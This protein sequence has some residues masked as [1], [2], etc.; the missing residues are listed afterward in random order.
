MNII[1]EI[2][3]Y[4]QFMWNF[5]S[6][7]VRYFSSYIDL[8]PIIF[9]HCISHV[10][11][12]DIFSSTRMGINITMIKTNDFY[13]NILIYWLFD[14]ELI[15]LCAFYIKLLAPACSFFIWECP[16]IASRKKCTFPTPLPC[17]LVTHSSYI[18]N[19][20]HQHESSRFPKLLP[21]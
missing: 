20:F 19:N 13:R 12:V 14:Q 21:K 6:T 11:L 15:N 7:M 10:I 18:G 8:I 4:V 5:F 17:V 9:L 3:V 1:S 2:D 16:L